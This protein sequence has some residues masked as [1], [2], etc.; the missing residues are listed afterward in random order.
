[1]EIIKFNETIDIWIDELSRFT[2]GQLKIKPDEKSWSLGQVYNHLIEETNWFNG[3]IEMTLGNDKNINEATSDDA[4]IL[5]RRG[6]FENK[7]F[8]SDPFIS[9][10]VKQ[11][12]TVAN[13]KSEI[14]Q[15]KKDTN[16]IWVK[17][18]NTTNYGKSEHPGLGFL[19]CYEW[20]QYSEMHMRHHLNQK[21]RIED[22]LKSIH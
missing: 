15:L 13:L 16:E 7:R 11:P 20:I 9:D 17:I 18:I 12:T 21:K 10:N 5:F 8:Q 3:Q 14:E 19:N 2:I 22:F 4:K 6:S 1:M